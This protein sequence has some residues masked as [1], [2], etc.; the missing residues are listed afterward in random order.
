MTVNNSN[1]NY[2]TSGL[3]NT[4]EYMASGLPWASASQATV[5]PYKISFPFVTNEIIIRNGGAAASPA[6]RIGFT[7]NGVNGVNYLSVGPTE[8]VTLRIRVKEIY[9]RSESSTQNW[10]ICA[11][12]TQIPVRGFPT[13]SGSYTYNQAITAS[14]YGYNGLG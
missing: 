9:V 12:L 5:T 14:V 10:S 3:N 4:A 7:T 13:L 2:P 8:H 11:G 6:L 1:F